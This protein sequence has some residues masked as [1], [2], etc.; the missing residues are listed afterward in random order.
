MISI[1]LARCSEFDITSDH[2][3]QRFMRVWCPGTL[4]LVGFLWILRA[5][6]G[7]RRTALHSNTLSYSALPSHALIPAN[8]GGPNLSTICIR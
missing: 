4:V 1:K 7:A 2:N 5:L 8:D 3:F 6:S